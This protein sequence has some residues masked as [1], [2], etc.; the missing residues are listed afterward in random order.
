M[1]QFVVLVNAEE[2]YS[3][4]P[5]ERGIPD[6]WEPAGIEGS[7]QT[8]IE[9]LDLHWQDMRPRSLREAMAASG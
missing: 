8:C 6:G 9:W 5:L 3:I 7:R 1:D 2:Q 4:I